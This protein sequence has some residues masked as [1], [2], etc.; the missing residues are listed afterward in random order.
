MNLFPVQMQP[1]GLGVPRAGIQSEDLAIE[2][3]EHRIDETT[4]T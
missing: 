1:G 3:L 2:I 4:D